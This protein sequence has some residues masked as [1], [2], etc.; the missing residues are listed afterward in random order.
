MLNPKFV[1]EFTF[2]SAEIIEAIR[3][4]NKHE[5]HLITKTTYSFI[6]IYGRLDLN[7][8]RG[9]IVFNFFHLFF[10]ALL[11]ALTV[12]IWTYVVFK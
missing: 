8:Y 7:L 5:K 12:F 1:S 10:I 9:K 3:R 6:T 11:T 2:N 4:T